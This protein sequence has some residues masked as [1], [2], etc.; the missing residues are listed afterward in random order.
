MREESGLTFRRI[1]PLASLPKGFA[2]GGE[3]Q[4]TASCFRRLVEI[5]DKFDRMS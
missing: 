1:F 5:I 4:R 2:Q 3:L